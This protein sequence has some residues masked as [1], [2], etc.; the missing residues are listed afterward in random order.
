MLLN[1]YNAGYAYY[2]SQS[3]HSQMCKRLSKH[4][5]GLSEHEN[6]SSDLNHSKC[7]GN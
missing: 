4:E 1:G 2:F 5:K 3:K 7:T 6:G